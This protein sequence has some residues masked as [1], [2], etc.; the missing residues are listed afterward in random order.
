MMLKRRGTFVVAHVFCSV[1]LAIAAGCGGDDDDDGTPTRGDGNVRDGTWRITST[2]S[3]AGLGEFCGDSTE[4]TVLM[5][6][7]CNLEEE[8]EQG[9]E[10]IP[11]TVSCDFQLKDVS[12]DMDC[13]G[14]RNYGTC[15]VTIT[16]TGFGEYHDTTYDFDGTAI[17]TT[18]P[19]TDCGI[20]TQPPCTLSVH[21]EGVWVNSTS[22]CEDDSTAA[23]TAVLG[24]FR[25]LLGSF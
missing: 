23:P 2:T 20:A 18:G 12:Y 13:T 1:L 16:F 6:P 22:D 25:R 4:T 14:T 24:S 11:I 7:I 3:S 8:F 17:I 19:V 10:G 21:E 15:P 9:L 5:E